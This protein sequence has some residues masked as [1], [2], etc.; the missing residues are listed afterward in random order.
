MQ[1]RLE[2]LIESLANVVI[3]FIISVIAQMVIMGAY[4]IDLSLWDNIVIVIYFTIISII[5]SYLLRRLFNKRV[6]KRYDNRTL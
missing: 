5:R 3:G 1:T 6:L 4:N 2:S